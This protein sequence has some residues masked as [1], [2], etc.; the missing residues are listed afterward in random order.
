M[1]T[2]GD[3]SLDVEDNRGP[4]D[5]PQLQDLTSDLLQF[6]VHLP[7]DPK[8]NTHWP[9][10]DHKSS[11]TDGGVVRVL[12][13]V[14]EECRI[15]SSRER[16]PFLVHV[17]VAETG[18]KGN[19]SRLYASGAPGLGATIEEALA[20]SASKLEGR[21]DNPGTEVSYHIP[22]ELLESTPF[23]VDTNMENVIEKSN[24]EIAYHQPPNSTD[25]VRG[26]DQSDETMFYAHNPDDVWASH[27]YDD[28][29]QSEFEQL[30]HQMY[31]DQ[32]VMQ[33]QPHFEEQR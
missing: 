6:S 33:P 9:G 19:D 22:L 20:M 23:P 8:Q 21:S 32:A 26:G 1:V 17:E 30:H 11:V 15:L 7:L 27:V 12:N 4:Y 24:S 10:G 13:I 25:F 2:R 31:V 5:W 14:V 28:V 29:R 3:V 18:L 16:C